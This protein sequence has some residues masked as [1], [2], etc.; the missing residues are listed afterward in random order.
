MGFEKSTSVFEKRRT[1][2]A[3]KAPHF[4]R[5]PTFRPPSLSHLVM[6]GTTQPRDKEY[7][8]ILRDPSHRR[9]C[10][11]PGVLSSPLKAVCVEAAAVG[12]VAHMLGL[13]ETRYL[14]VGYRIQIHPKQNFKACMRGNL[15][16]KPWSG[17]HVNIDLKPA[18]PMSWH[19]PFLF[20]KKL[21]HL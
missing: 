19:F 16:R 6:P 4:V 1:A 7:G 11:V 18:L 2:T 13:S 10:R 21:S 20:V 9:R 17:T 3:I 15:L 12:P 5:E 14:P 8:D